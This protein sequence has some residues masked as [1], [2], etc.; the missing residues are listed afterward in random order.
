MKPRICVVTAGHLSTCP[1]MLKAA[2]ALSRAGYAVHV[3]ST[4]FLPWAVEADRHARGSRENLW[5]WSVISY[6]PL[7]ESQRLGAFTSL[8]LRAARLLAGAFRSRAIPSGILARGFVRVHPELVRAVV[9]TSSDLIYGGGGALAVA[10]E[11][12]RHSGKPYGLDL[13]DFHSAESGDGPEGKL[14]DQIAERIERRTLSG[15]RFLTAAGCAIAAAYEEKYGVRPVPIN[16]TFPLPARAPNFDE[17]RKPG[18]KLY[19]FSQTVSHDRGLEDAVN[20]MGKGGLDG[21]LHLRGRPARGYLDDLRSLAS[22]AAPR[23]RIVHHEPAF[24]DDM[25]ELCRGYDVGLSLEQGHVFNKTVC[26]G[27]K[28]LTYILAGVPVALTDT[29]GQ[30]PLAQDLGAGAALY[31]PGDVNRLASELARWANDRGELE[32]AR[33]AAWD[34]ARRRWHWEHPLER[35]ALLDAVSGALAR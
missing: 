20:A 18:L 2:D 16:N 22:T 14:R 32:R 13:E 1:R 11:A 10:A 31:H 5:D 27:N 28:P 23:L 33:Q 9:R 21:E 4:R 25:V 26:L 8:R 12:A 34:A 19:W 3:V 35:G 7:A 24:P 6:G 30:R 17:S 29:T 15:A